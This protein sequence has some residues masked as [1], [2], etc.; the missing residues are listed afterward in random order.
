ML[1]E[2]LDSPDDF[3]ESIRRYSYSLGTTLIYGWRTPT[4]KDPR[5]AKL[6]EQLNELQE[7]L[8]TG[9]AAVL[10]AFPI[11]R[12]L[13]DWLLPIKAQAYE[14]LQLG[15]K[16]HMS[17]WQNVKRNIADETINPCLSVGLIKAEEK[18]E[19]SEAEAAYTAGNILEGAGETTTQTLYAF[20]QAMILF[21]EVQAKAQAE[22]DRVVGPDRL[23]TMQDAPNMPY[24][25]RCVKELVRWFPAGPTGAMP[26]ATTKDDEYMG[27]FIPKG[28]AV[29]LN[30]WAIS[31]DATRFP[32]PRR[33]NPDRFSDESDHISMAE[34]AAHPDPSK[35]DTVRYVSRPFLPCITSY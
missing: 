33:F 1:V 30:V 8:T 18:K 29:M 3:F 6:F 21:P 10:D 35:R 12:Y 22:I 24:I 9:A 23:P 25:R 2:F 14:A 28:A 32:E 31:T 4:S 34:S 17:N 19:L 27:Y 5:A 13:P 15:D 16:F 20:V 11:V 26:H 7:V